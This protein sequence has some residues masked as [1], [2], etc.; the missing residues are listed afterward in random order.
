MLL[1]P[2]DVGSGYT[3]TAAGEGDWTFEFNA[4]VLD[5]PRGTRPEPVAE[6]GRALH[7][8]QPQ[9]DTFV[10]QHLGRYPAGQAAR[11]LDRIRER[12][13]ACSPD[14]E[15]SVRVAAEGFAGDEALLV[16]FDHGGGS[17][18]KLVLVREGDLLTEIYSKPERSDSAS[19]ELGRK[20]A[21]RF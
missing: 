10:V 17:L 12:V 6:R 1:R 7:K 20:A 19:R 18:A 3:A 14:N 4:A 21:A 8:G 2:Q 9:D 11:Y 5:C 15:R 16:V 13:S